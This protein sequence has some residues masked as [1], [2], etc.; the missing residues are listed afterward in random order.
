MLRRLSVALIASLTA[1]SCGGDSD[2]DGVDTGVRDGAGGDTG[3]RNTGGSNTGGSNTGGSNTGGN[4]TGGGL[5]GGVGGAPDAG[6]GHDAGGGSG[7]T[8][9]A[10]GASGGPPGA[11]LRGRFDPAA[12]PAKFGW[13]G[14]ALAIRFQGT[15]A[16]VRLD[17]SPNQFAIVVN[18]GTPTVLKTNG[19][20]APYAVASG[21][22]AGVYDLLIWRRTEG[23]QGENTFAEVTIDG[24]QLLSP[25]ERPPRAIEVYGDSISAGYGIEGVGPNCPYSAD[26]ENHY[27]TYEAIAARALGAE[28]HS[29]VWS[30]IGMYRNYNQV[31]PSP[32]AMPAVYAR[33][34][35]TVAQSMWDFSTWQPDAVVINLGTNDVSTMGDPGMPY[36]DAYLKF[37]RGLRTRY[38]N[39]YFV[40]TIGPM[41]SGTA[42]VALKG[43]INAVIQTLA[44]EGDE[45]LSFLEFPVQVAADGYGCDYHPSVAT[46]AKM[47]TLLTAELKTRLMW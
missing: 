47:G 6:A 36:R 31:G 46:Q 24:G 7:G 21:L 3:G 39:T 30:G 19:A 27:L 17:G 4:N 25:P 2:S 44:G 45:R 28:V 9:G 34:L 15:G 43:H 38:P 32:D 11:Q 29:I 33:A 26:T 23:N 14:S 41:V 8:T 35:P 1:L 10:G 22:A 37:V 16:R 13:S 12:P 42:L 20:T 18:G 40:L 5:G